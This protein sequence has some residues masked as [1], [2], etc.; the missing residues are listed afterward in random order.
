MKEGN[1]RHLAGRCRGIKRAVQTDERTRGGK[2]KQEGTKR[3]VGR[4]GYKRGWW[5]VKQGQSVRLSG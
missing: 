4:K 3:G 1:P 5:H 2:G